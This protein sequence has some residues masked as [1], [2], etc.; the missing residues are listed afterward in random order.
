MPLIAGASPLTRGKRID[1][2]LGIYSLGRIPAHAGKTSRGRRAHARWGAHPRSRGENVYGVRHIPG[3]GGAS[4]LTR[5]KHLPLDAPGNGPGRIPAH[6]GKTWPWPRPCR[7][8][9][10]HPRSRGENYNDARH[11]LAVEGASPLTRGKPGDSRLPA[12]AR[13]AHPRSRG[14]N[15]VPTRS[16]GNGRGASPLTRGK[17]RRP[18]RTHR[19]PWA[20]PRSRGEN[21]GRVPELADSQGASPLT[22]GKPGRAGDRVRDLGRIPAHAGKTFAIW[23]Q[24]CVARAHPRSRGENDE[25]PLEAVSAAGASP[26][27]RGKH[28][29]TCAFIA[30]IGQILESRELC[31]SS[32]SYSLRNVYATAAPQDQVRS[33]GLAPLSSRGAS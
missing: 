10:A 21:D 15:R 20:H 31:A 1:H 24:S 9:G 14:E 33:I 11:A 25:T 8:P 26:L 2:T 28:F 18:G 13:R 22:R 16:A 23:F 27:T 4:P 32:E 6:A 5:G 7:R 3:C 30:Q 29:L 12:P 19:A 17:P